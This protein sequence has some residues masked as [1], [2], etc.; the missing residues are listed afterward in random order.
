MGIKTN[1]I[2][3][4]N[5]LLSY[6]GYRKNMSFGDSSKC[7]T[8]KFIYDLRESGD[9]SAEA[10]AMC[11]K[12]QNLRKGTISFSSFSDEV[13]YKVA[14]TAVADINYDVD[15]NTDATL[16]MH[17]DVTYTLTIKTVSG[18]TFPHPT[19]GYLHL[20]LTSYL[21]CGG[22]DTLYFFNN[23]TID[24]GGK[25]YKAS[26]TIP[27]GIFKYASFAVDKLDI[28]KG[29]SKP[30]FTY[31]LTASVSEVE[32][33]YFYN[34][35]LVTSTRLLQTAE[36]SVPILFYMK[37]NA[38]KTNID[39]IKTSCCCVLNGA[40]SYSDYQSGNKD[41]N[42]ISGSD[43]ES[44]IIYVD[45]NTDTIGPSKV[46]TDKSSCLN[47]LV[48]DDGNATFKQYIKI[49]CRGKTNQSLGTL[50]DNSIYKTSGS[51][52]DVKNYTL[53]IGA[54]NLN[55]VSDHYLDYWKLLGTVDS[56]GNAI[57]GIYVTIDS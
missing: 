50:W 51:K 23:I 40:S 41:F 5:D 12:V 42:Q 52:S 13:D 4:Q 24:P 46:D 29:L 44:A 6:M 37:N 21:E 33:D 27:K 8:E 17:S 39:R 30:A 48:T 31:T 19:G 16:I 28:P 43:Y 55:P 49:D 26:V 25:T 38:S 15:P 36:A 35:K 1:Q 20:Q 32:M 56:D 2:P 47:I 9:A 18:S 34:T 53:T 57:T 14:P 10:R 54:K 11:T 3:T 22:M 7:V 45:I